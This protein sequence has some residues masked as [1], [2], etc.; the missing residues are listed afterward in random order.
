MSAFD[1]VV[2]VKA[3]T[4]STFQL[5]DSFI[6]YRLVVA[7]ELFGRASKFYFPKLRSIGSF[8]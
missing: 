2:R 5:A 6:A 7:S 3:F 4:F 1:E 8:S